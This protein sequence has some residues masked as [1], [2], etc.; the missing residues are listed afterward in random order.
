M[1]V[2]SGRVAISGSDALGVVSIGNTTKFASAFSETKT[3]QI[4]P[5]TSTPAAFRATQSLHVPAGTI[6]KISVV[7]N[8]DVTTT[9]SIV[10]SVDGAA[11]TTFTLAAKKVT[12]VINT[13]V[14]TDEVIKVSLTD[15]VGDLSGSGYSVT[16]YGAFLK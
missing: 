13:P 12:A 7:L 14:G 10:L 11:I 4:N 15:T 5:A 16:L 8:D 2:V 9:G 6:G 1:G 3:F